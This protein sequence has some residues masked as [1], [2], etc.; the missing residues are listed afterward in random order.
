MKP[1]LKLVPP[2][3]PKY[4]NHHPFLI[5]IKKQYG[6]K[7]VARIEIDDLN[8]KNKLIKYTKVD[9][10]CTDP[11]HTMFNYMFIASKLID[12]T[13]HHK[14]I[15]TGDT[16][17]DKPLLIKTAGIR[18]SKHEYDQRNGRFGCYL[19]SGGTNK[20]VREIIVKYLKDGWKVNALVRE[21]LFPINRREEMT[22]YIE[23][24]IIESFRDWNNVLPEGNECVR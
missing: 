14:L 2:L 5:D 13:E 7:P 1:K 9:P 20:M 12:A 15:K 22:G 23:Q 16:I 19:T 3:L 4:D 8:D 18:R 11:N 21:C 6:F 10:I 17:D 24:H